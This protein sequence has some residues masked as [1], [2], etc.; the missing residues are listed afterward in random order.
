MTYEAKPTGENVVGCCGDEHLK[1]C[2]ADLQKLYAR[3]IQLN[4]SQPLVA[5]R[6]ALLPSMASERS[7]PKASAL[8]LPMWASHL[9]EASTEAG[10]QW[11]GMDR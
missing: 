10:S 8:W 6:E 11:S 7:D 9:V 3:D 2:L 1:R 5:V 4:V